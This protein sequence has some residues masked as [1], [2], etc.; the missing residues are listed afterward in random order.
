MGLFDKKYCD[1]CGEKISL[2]GNKKLE[3][4]NLCKDCAAKLSP[5]FSDR[6]RS[7]VEDIKAQLVYREENK[8]KVAA[9]HTTKTLGKGTKVLLDEDAGC[10]IVTAAGN[11]TQAN[12]DVMLLSDI[13]GCSVDTDENRSELKRRTADGKE[14]SFVPPRYEYRYDFYVTVNVNNPYFNEIRFR[15]NP[16]TV[17]IE[18]GP[19]RP[20][21]AFNPKTNPEYLE[22]QNLGSEIKRTLT[23]VQKQ[24]RADAVAAAAPRKKVTCPY[25][26]ATTIPDAS[27]CCEYCGGAVNG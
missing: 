24:I 15:L 1:V 25:C 19:V 5:W 14:V 21:M 22:Y 20:G 11:L 26:G 4:G 16:S 7:T 2:L 13:T 8:A 17:T 9:F 23:Q 18:P 27:G 3:D 10:F 12:P 6:K